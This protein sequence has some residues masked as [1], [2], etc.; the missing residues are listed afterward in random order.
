[1]KNVLILSES[2]Q[3]HFESS[4]RCKCSLGIPPD[5]ARNFINLVAFLFRH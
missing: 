4:E 5:F 2:I 1:M 3:N